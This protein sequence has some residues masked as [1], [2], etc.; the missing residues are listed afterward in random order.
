MNKTVPIIDSRPF[1]LFLDLDGVFA[2]F[3]KGVSKM[4]GGKHISEVPKKDMWRY[5]NGHREGFF[6]TLEMMEDAEHLWN[7]TKQYDPTIL[8]G[9]PSMSTGRSQKTAWVHT[10]LVNENGWQADKIII[11]PKKEKQL[12]S[13]PRKVLLDDTQINIDQWVD[14]GGIGILHDGDVWKTVNALEEL[15]LSWPRQ[16]ASFCISE[17]T[18]R[19][20]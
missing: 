12:H 2:H 19:L 10:N 6:L 20:V 8:S 13:G 5:I 16:C 17:E 7:Y 1:D 9:L 18:D 14:Q 11:L 4:F 15:R 3:D